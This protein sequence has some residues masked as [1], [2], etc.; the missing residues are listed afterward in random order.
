MD[1]LEPL[2]KQ[3][4]DILKYSVQDRATGQPVD[5]LGFS[6]AMLADTGSLVPA[7]WS[8]TRDHYLGKMWQQ[9]P[10]FAGA[11]YNVAAKLATIPPII[12]PRDPTSK[13]QRDLAEKYSIMLYE[14][15]EFGRGYIEFAMKWCLDRWTQDNGAFAEVLGD[16]PK[17]GPIVGPARGLANLDSQKST[18]TGHPI[19]PV[20]YQADTG[21]RHKL[22]YTRVVFGSQIP[23]TRDTMC[24]V[25]IS[26]FSRCIGV[27]Q[28]IVDDLTYKQEKLGKRPKRAILVGKK[29]DV[30]MITTAFKLADEGADNAGLS[31][32]SLMPVIANP[33]AADVGIDIVDLASLPDG[34]EWQTDVNI[35]MYIIALTGGFPVRWM[36]PATVVGATKADAMIQHMVGAMSGTAHEMGTLALMLGGSDKGMSHQAGKFLPQTLKIRYEVQDDWIDDVQAGIRLQRANTYEKNLADQSVTIRVTREQMLGQGEI[37]EAQFR[38]MELGNGRTQDGLPI[39]TLF[40][41]DNPFLSGIDPENY[42]EEEV[43]KALEKAKRASVQQTASREEAREAVAAIEWLLSGKE[44]SQ[45]VELDQPAQDETPSPQGETERTDESTEPEEVVKS[46][47]EFEGD[48][49]Q[50]LGDLLGGIEQEFVDDVDTGKQPDYDKLGML[51]LA[52][53]I[54]WLVKGFM[55]RARELE[56][57]FGISLDPA[58]WSALAAAWATDYG[59]NL[60]TELT[61]TTRKVVDRALR[62]AEDMTQEQIRAMLDPAFSQ[63]RADMISITETTRAYTAAIMEY[64]DM[65]KERYGLDF[66]LVV[67]TAQDEKVCEHICAPLD[68]KGEDVW[69]REYPDGS[70][71]HGR[72]RCLME[73]RLRA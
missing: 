59:R 1:G 39:D 73:L 42:T 67:R 22:H 21:K 32:V 64:R 52:F 12:E 25:G 58:E 23:S 28:S 5:G 2:E 16:G 71:F 60:V 33:N 55:D 65:L 53:L 66:E 36:W 40:Y 11:L 63:A 48:M 14:G 20:V 47:F 68:G 43:K 31:R 62:V 46:R 51:L 72:C 8:T 54:G 41:T 37:T 56:D 49:A 7:W 50:E 45:E 29:I 13:T 4:E 38:D 70:P 17:D 35:G 44:E 27:A 26:W 69:S 9:C 15:S 10:L 18:R 3:T 19:W 34:F 24:N 30:S 6:F 61:N 57:E